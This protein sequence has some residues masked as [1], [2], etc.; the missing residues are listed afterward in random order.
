MGSFRDLTVYKKS[1]K[2]AMEIFELTKGFAQEEKYAL[3]S[4]LRRSSRSVARSIGEAYRKRNYPNHFVSKISDADM[5]NTETM[6]SLDFAESCKYISNE[7]N[8]SLQN[9]LMEVGKLLNHM[10]NNPESYQR[11]KRN[12]G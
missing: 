9:Q 4:Q 5:E 7:Q 10:M 8:I 6:I 11:K 12:S 3:T 1:Y 2:A